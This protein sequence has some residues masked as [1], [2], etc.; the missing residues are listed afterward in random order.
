MVAAAVQTV[1]KPDLIQQIIDEVSQY[2]YPYD[3]REKSDV[4]DMAV[5]DVLDYLHGLKKKEAT[6]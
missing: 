4:Y 5:Q 2:S 6:Q 1:Q 3:N